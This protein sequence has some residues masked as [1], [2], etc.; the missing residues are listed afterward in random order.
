MSTFSSFTGQLFL[1]TASLLG[2]TGA[3]IAAFTSFLPQP[4]P[5]PVWV[6]SKMVLIVICG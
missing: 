4:H 5:N 3:I 1:G 2:T 6:I